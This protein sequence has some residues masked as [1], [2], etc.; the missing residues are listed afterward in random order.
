MN[1]AIIAGLPRVHPNFAK[2]P[3][4]DRLALIVKN[5]NQLALK[6]TN[7]LQKHPFA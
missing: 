4:G 5:D 7:L 3:G 2:I 1:T 6:R